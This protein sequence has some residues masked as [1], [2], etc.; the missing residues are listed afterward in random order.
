MQLAI[1]VTCVASCFYLMIRKRFLHE[2]RL[3]PRKKI[4]VCQQDAENSRL[5]SCALQST[6]EQKTIGPV[7]SATLSAALSQRGA[8]SLCTEQD[9]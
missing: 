5:L 1:D 6:V 2:V 9:K 3:Q 7:T 4:E 8:K